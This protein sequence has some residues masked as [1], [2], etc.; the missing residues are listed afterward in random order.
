[1]SEL[2]VK[3]D[4]LTVKPDT[5]VHSE[6]LEPLNQASLEGVLCKAV[7]IR[8]TPAGRPVARFELEH[9]ARTQHAAT[10]ER[11]A[12]RMTVVAI[13][14]LAEACRRLTAG[15]RLL[16]HGQ[17]NQKRWIREGQVRWGRA[18]LVALEILP[19]PQDGEESESGPSL[20]EELLNQSASGQPN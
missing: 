5:P 7:K 20:I 8:V 14:S 1:M 10:G 16:V 3:P 11:M 13:G 18:E 9:I 12:L 4:T 15:T 2:P 17:L 19:Q 6:A